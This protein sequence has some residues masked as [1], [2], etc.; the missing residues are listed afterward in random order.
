[1]SNKAQTS[2]LGDLAKR[3][4]LLREK[5]QLSQSELARRC[6][7]DHGA[8]SR[9]ESGSNEPTWRTLK[10]IA[11]GL[12]IPMYAIFTDEL[13]VAVFS[14]GIEARLKHFIDLQRKSLEFAELLLTEM[15]SRH[16]QENT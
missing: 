15:E 4:K 2:E 1:M 11:N 9:I 10:S 12:G 13:D 14:A 6:G 8:F 5:Q 16:E 7:I 3:L